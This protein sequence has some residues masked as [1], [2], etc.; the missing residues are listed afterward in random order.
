MMFSSLWRTNSLKIVSFDGFLIGY[1]LFLDIYSRLVPVHG[2]S[3]STL[4][5]HLQN[6]KISLFNN[7]GQK[8]QFPRKLENIQK[9]III[10]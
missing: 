7:E 6:T 3:H 2:A 8:K 4:I 5:G 9:S 1:V 10:R